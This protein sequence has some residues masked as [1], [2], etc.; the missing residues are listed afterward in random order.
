M[1][2]HARLGHTGTGGR[3]L[4][5]GS[6]VV[7]L[8]RDFANN[9]TVALSETE[10]ALRSTIAGNEVVHGSALHPSVSPVDPGSHARPTSSDC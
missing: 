3:D 8:W 4:E 6:V 9:I 2:V 10:I 7:R 5:D 1:P